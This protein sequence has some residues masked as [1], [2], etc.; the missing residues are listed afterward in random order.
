M[1]FGILSTNRGNYRPKIADNFMLNS[2]IF[3][4]K[5]RD[6]RYFLIKYIKIY[7]ISYYM[8]QISE[9]EQFR[10]LIL[11]AH[12]TIETDFNLFISKYIFRCCKDSKAKS[13]DGSNI[14]Q[15]LIL[16]NIN[17]NKKREIIFDSLLC[18][19]KYRGTFDNVASINIDVSEH[20]KL[21]RRID[22]KIRKLN[23]LR[24]KIAHKYVLMDEEKF[25][26][27]FKNEKKEIKNVFTNMAKVS[28]SFINI[29]AEKINI[30]KWY[31]EIDDFFR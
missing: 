21:A 27:K 15:D 30:N 9:I 1:I 7:L 25:L 17:F 31:Q 22:G 12:L 13:I 6:A 11:K 4:A 20:M 24:N 16:D 2:I 19:K 18:N 14:F 23:N 5:K 10:I 26:A 28:E 29:K 3:W 8:D